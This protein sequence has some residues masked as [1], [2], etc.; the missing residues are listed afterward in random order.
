MKAHR[1]AQAFASMAAA[2]DAHAQREDELV[3]EL[4]IQH[5]AEAATAAAAATFAA[6]QEH[7]AER[8]SLE[9]NVAASSMAAAAVAAQNK[10]SD[11]RGEQLLEG[12]HGSASKAV[13]AIRPDEHL[14]MRACSALN[15]LLVNP[16]KNDVLICCIHEL[17]SGPCKLVYMCHRNMCHR[18]QKKSAFLSDGGLNKN[19]IK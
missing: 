7:M 9:P 3:R 17:C 6:E 19:V 4:L 5:A 14:K 2:K 13:A 12:L 18:H 1:A 16:V 8:A 15:P 10:Q 11:R